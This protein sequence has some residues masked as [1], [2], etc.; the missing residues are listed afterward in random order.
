MVVLRRRAAAL[1]GLTSTG[2]S[3]RAME[4]ISEDV[5]TEAYVAVFRD[6]H[7]IAAFE[8]AVPHTAK[9]SRDEISKRRGCAVSTRA[10]IGR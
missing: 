10:R 9:P 2:N 4:Q 6:G 7:M 8:I 1:R 5:V 3:V